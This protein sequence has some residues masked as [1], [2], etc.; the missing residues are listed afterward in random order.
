MLAIIQFG[1]NHFLFLEIVTELRKVPVMIKLHGSQ[2]QT[3]LLLIGY[4][5]LGKIQLRNC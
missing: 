1:Q 4:Y 3:Q 2:K 5:F